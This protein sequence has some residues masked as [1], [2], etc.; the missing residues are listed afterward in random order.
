MEMKIMFCLVIRK[1]Y[2][3]RF[4]IKVLES[5][6]MENHFNAT[7]C[8][9]F[10]ESILHLVKSLLGYLRLCKWSLAQADLIVIVATTSSCVN[11]LPKLSCC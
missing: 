5:K 9:W 8:G 7:L 1:L 10:S 6:T 2:I 3:F 4:R 11:H